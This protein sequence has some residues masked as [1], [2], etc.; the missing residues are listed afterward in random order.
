MPRR[1]IVL[2]Q[3]AGERGSGGGGE[4][5]SVMDLAVMAN[6]QKAKRFVSSVTRLSERAR[7][8]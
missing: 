3:I 7:S 6:E 5:G 2:K 4:G 8:D 1:T